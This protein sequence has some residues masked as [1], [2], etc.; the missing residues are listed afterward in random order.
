MTSPLPTAI[1]A[2]GNV[3][4]TYVVSIASPSAPAASELTA[5]TSIDLQCYLNEFSPGTDQGSIPDQRI[6]QTQDNERPGR[7]KETLEV[8]YVYQAQSPAATDNKA[9]ATL[10]EGT[11]GY[12]AARWGMA[13]ATAWAA[14]QYADVWTVT[15]GVPVKMPPEA[16]GLLRIKQKLFVTN[17]VQRDKVVV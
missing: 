6:C 3:K 13:Q 11:A 12:I 5:G 1:P 14:G 15:A 16:D 4:V 9:Q 17:T 8:T 10:A 7:K 2:D